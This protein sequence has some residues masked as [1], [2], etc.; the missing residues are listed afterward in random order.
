MSPITIAINESRNGTSATAHISV[1]STTALSGKKLFTVVVEHHHNFT[2]AGTNGEKDFYYI[3]RKMFPNEG[4]D[5]SLSAGEVKTF[6]I[7]YSLDPSW[8]ANDIYIVSFVQDPNTK[9]VMQVGTNRGKIDITTDA[10]QAV[11]QSSP[12]GAQWQSTMR[13]N[14]PGTYSVAITQKMPAGWTNTVTIGGVAVSNGGTAAIADVEGAGMNVAIVPSPAAPGKGWVTVTLTGDHGTSLTRTF[15]CYS[16]GLQ[17]LVLP[18]D[19]GD[20]NITNSYDQGL[21]KTGY[22]YAIVDQGDEDIF[23]LNDHVIIYE[24]GKWAITA[25]E[26]PKLE[27]FFDKGGR[28]F[29]IGAEIGY[30]LA[31]PNNS[32][33]ISPRNVDFMQRYLHAS[34]V[35]D[36]SGPFTIYGATNGPIG[37]GLSFSIANGV[38]NEN[39]PDQIAPLD[40]ATPEFY[41]GNTQTKV[42]GIRYADGKNRL[43][44]LGFGAE[45]IGDQ[46][47]RGEVLKRGIAWLLGSDVTSGVSMPDAPTTALAVRPN[48][49]TGIFEVPFSL[50]RS[51]HCTVA[52]YNSVGERVAVLADATYPAGAAS[53][54]FD[55]TGLPSGVYAV[56]LTAPG[57]TGSK[58]I[59]IAH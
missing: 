24:V 11:V 48:P 41:Y 53:V 38:Q 3:A 39:T 4:S 47:K 14:N 13:T 34:Y 5:L 30:G 8:N 51:S 19:E 55:G 35:A 36:S 17:A 26:V 7:D 10:P 23:N 1:T 33:P 22:S 40:G 31:D 56:V 27:S 32:D 52:L 18:R 57:F 2:N 29:I 25:A 6:D 50:E 49:T 15:R 21:G 54:R 42:A 20:V 28:M 44:Y 46:A 37:D 58:M 45:G 16:S 9:E 43:V 12:D 59:T